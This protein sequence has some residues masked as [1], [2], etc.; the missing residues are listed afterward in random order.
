V[1][2]DLITAGRVFDD[3]GRAAE[4]TRLQGLSAEAFAATAETARQFAETKRAADA[5]AAANRAQAGDETHPMGTQG[6]VKPNAGD[7]PAGAAAPSAGKEPTF[8]EKLKDGV[9][10]AYE[11]SRK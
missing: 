4:L 11:A 9:L 2:Q 3:K 8:A 6:A 7:P 10:A 5:A 1:L